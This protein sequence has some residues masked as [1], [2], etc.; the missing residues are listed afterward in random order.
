MD[1]ANKIL[2]QFDNFAEYTKGEVSGILFQLE[3]RNEECQQS[4]NLLEGDLL[5]S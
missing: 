2:F 1:T 3:E 5:P 4:L